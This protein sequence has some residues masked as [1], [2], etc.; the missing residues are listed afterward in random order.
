MEAKILNVYSNEAM[1]GSELR[2]DHGQSFLI[3]IGDQ[4][5]L[6]DV[7]AQGDILLHNM[8]VLG[9][10]ADDIERLVLSHGHYD[11]TKG[12]PEFIDSRTIESPLKVIAHPDIREP[13]RG[14]IG[15]I[16]KNL[17]FPNLTQDQENMLEFSFSK[18]SQRLNEYLITTGEIRE[19]P[20]RDGREPRALHLEDGKWV[21]DP[22]YDDISLVLSTS[23]G[24]VII[25]GCA[26]AGILNICRFA[27]DS[28]EAPI[29]AIIGGSH[30]A[31]YSEEEV[32]LTGQK[33]KDDF[34]FP[35]LY[36]NHCTDKLPYRF[37]KTTNVIDILKDHYSADKVKNC[38]VGTELS[39][40]V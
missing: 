38:Y 11:H 18:T 30:M 25:T 2:G 34:D 14:K 39:F 13:R 31:R 7:G 5:I 28:S 36:L 22:V 9:I 16:K 35:E 1:P 10:S 26:H 4:K 24:Q 12:L 21:V 32:I 29:Q 19:R 6:M 8:R 17:G 15:P 33:L 23:D 20:E 3:T 40:Q 37:L 27:K